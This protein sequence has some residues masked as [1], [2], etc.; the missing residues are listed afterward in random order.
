VAVADQRAGQLEQAEVGVGSPLVAGAQSLEGVQ[1]GEAALDHPALFAQRRAVGDAAA[2]DPRRDPA[3]AQMAAVDVVVVAAVGEQLPR[4]PAGRPRRPRIGG[5]AST[6]FSCVTSLRLPPV[7]LTASGMPPASQIRWCLE[8]ER[9]RSTGEGPTWSLHRQGVPD[10]RGEL[11]ELSV[12]EIRH[13][14]TCLVWHLAPEPNRVLHWSRWRRGHQARARR[15]H[16]A[17]RQ[18]R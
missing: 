11:T 8:P 9:P 12:P 10:L 13:L 3:G 1:P 17:S 4:P 7:R 14:I 15:C 18:A 5:M 16:Y 6:G 2:G